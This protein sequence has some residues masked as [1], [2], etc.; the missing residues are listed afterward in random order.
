METYKELKRRQEKEFYEFPKE[1]ALNDQRLNEILNEWGCKEEDVF[2]IGGG[3]I[4]RKTDAGRFAEMCE[5]HLRELQEALKNDKTGEGFIYEAFL[6]ELGNYEYGYTEDAEPA[7]LALG[8]SEEKVQKDKALKHGFKKAS[9]E[10]LANA[11]CI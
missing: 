4:I 2:T 9:K 5:R 3:G 6:H 10:V 8:L 11:V 7:L 1:Y